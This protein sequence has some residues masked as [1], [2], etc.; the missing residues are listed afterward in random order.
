VV[1]ATGL[2]L[3]LSGDIPISLDGQP[4]KPAQTVVYKGLMSSGVPN[5]AST[6]GYTNASWTLKADLSARY[7]CRLLNHM[8][9]HGHQLCTPCLDAAVA[10]EPC[11]DFSSGYVQRALPQLPRQGLRR[12]WKLYQNYLRDWLMLRLGRVDDGV[13]R[14]GSGGGPGTGPGTGPERGPAAS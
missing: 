6:F 11:L 2:E 3:A 5:L 14:F 9:R 13:L 12:P 1:T 10:T 4:V 8:D 7:L